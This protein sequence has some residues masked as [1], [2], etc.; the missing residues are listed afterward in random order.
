MGQTAKRVA[1][2]TVIVI[3]ILATALA[4]WKLKL[5]IALVF[6]GFILAAMRPGIDGLRR[7]GVPRAIGLMPALLVLISVTS[8]G[9][10][11]G[12]FAVIAVPL[13]AVLVTVI[14]VV[15]RQKEP[16]EEEIPTVLFPAKEAEN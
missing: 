13:V 14:D 12:A 1:L 5:V 16:A 3:A 9:I 4:L 11:F 2:A 8:V 7:R 10:L 15:V 6:L